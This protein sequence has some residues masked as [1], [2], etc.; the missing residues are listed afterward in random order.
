STGGAVQTLASPSFAES[1]PAWSP[2]GSKIAYA[3]S[4]E[5]WIMNADGSGRQTLTTSAAG[6]TSPSWAP[7]GD[8]I[9]YADGG[10]LFA[11]TASGSS[12]R[13]FADATGASQPDWGLAVAS[14]QAPTITVQ[15]GG[16][17]AEGSQLSADLGTWTSLSG[18]TSYAYQWKRCGSSGT[19]CVPISGATSGIYQLA[20][21]DVGSTIRVT[22]TAT[23]PDGSAPGTSAPTVLI[24]SA[25]PDNVTPPVITGTAIVG[26]TLTAA[27]G[28]WT[29]SNPVFTYQWKGCDTN[30]SNCQNISG[31][32]ANVYVPGTADIGKTLRVDVT[33]T[34]ADGSATETSNPTPLVSSN[35]PTNVAL[36]AITESTIGTS[37]TYEATTGTWN[38]AATI[39]YKYQWRR[40]DSNGGNCKDIAAAIS[41]RYTPAAGDIGSRLRVAVTASNSFGQASAVSEAS[42]LIS[43]NAPIN[44]FR[45]SISGTER[46][47][48]T[49]FASPGS[50][51]G[52]APIT[53]TYEWRRCNASG[54]SCAAILGAT[55]SSY[56]AQNTDVGATLMVAVTA[57]NAAGT[58]TALSDITDA[59][60]A[61]TT[62]TTTATRPA[63]TSLPS[64]SGVL[65]RGQTLRAVNG[66]WS[67]TTPM[68]FSYQWQRCPRTGTTCTAIALAT[69]SSYVLNAADVNR[70]IRLLVTAANVAGPTQ[71]LSAISRLVAARAPAVAKGKTIRGNARANRLTGTNRADTIH[72]LAGNDR[73]NPRRGRD[74]VFAGAGNDIVNAVDGAKDTIDCGAGR[75]DRVTAD[76]IDTVKKNCERITRKAPARRR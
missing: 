9:V 20:N 46:A 52:S 12:I 8:E 21:G 75:R 48:S 41:S 29:G 14:T 68:T 61:G 47:G 27:P 54:G 35:V 1:D 5:I 36:P 26:S 76:R 69:R 19:G 49:L 25:A 23:T 43:G 63:N 72:G 60:A 11:I 3:A 73:I 18:I 55:S 71:A 6:A 39:I 40:C 62:G 22:V 58:A 34:N 7:G 30:G 31:A 50:W 64:F 66:T 10:E 13:Q 70:R 51:T 65:A 53:Y 17:Y 33:G 57:R 32:T 2:D 56:I 42:E 28:T 44:S 59:I 4:G 15:S 37:T 74:S 24:G 38:G 45:P 16:A 67:G